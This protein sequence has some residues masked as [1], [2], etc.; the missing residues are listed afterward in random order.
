MT[1]IAVTAHPPLAP[2]SG[3]RICGMAGGT[4]SCRVSC[5]VGGGDCGGS[6]GDRSSWRRCCC[7]LCCCWNARTAPPNQLPTFPNN[8][9]AALSLEL[10][11]ILAMTSALGLMTRFPGHTLLG[12]TPSIDIRYEPLL[13]LIL[14]Y[15]QLCYGPAASEDAAR[16]MRAIVIVAAASLLLFS[17]PSTG[18]FRMP[19]PQQTTARPSKRAITFR[20]AE[21][22]TTREEQLRR[23]KAGLIALNKMAEIARERRERRRSG[24]AD[25]D[26]RRNTAD[27]RGERSV[28]GNA[29]KPSA[30]QQTPARSGA[31][32]GSLIETTG[33]LAVARVQLSMLNQRDRMRARLDDFL[34]GPA[35]AFEAAK[36]SIGL[37]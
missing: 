2:G 29:R 23:R 4:A 25:A 20:R 16:D 10:F 32:L 12:P 9:G 31:T 17:E 27:R 35:S 6:C 8:V 11:S 26:K 15:G 14:Q 1:T 30:D 21:T 13:Y 5:R 36:R 19:P 24:T 7:C 34:S 3:S 28:M 22:A 37:D 33:Q 18:F